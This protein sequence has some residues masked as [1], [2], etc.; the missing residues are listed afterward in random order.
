[1]S[2]EFIKYLKR[3]SY[4]PSSS[5]A[6]LCF[7]K[8]KPISQLQ[9]DKLKNG[10]LTYLKTHEGAYIT[11]LADHLDTEPKKV[12]YAIRELKEDGLLI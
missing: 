8:V 6:T 5:T 10:I 3:G 2:D 4:F 12:V 1:M 11:E 9:L 7:T